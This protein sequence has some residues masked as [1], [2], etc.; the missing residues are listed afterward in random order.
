MNESEAI[1]DLSAIELAVEFT[2]AD[3]HSNE[4]YL[5]RQSGDFLYFSDLG[6]SDEE[7]DDFEDSMR[8][9]AMP[10]QHE[11]GLGRDLAAKFVAEQAPH[12]ADDLR[13]AFS[14]RGGY[15]RFKALMETHGLLD[16]WYEYESKAERQAICRWCDE[17][18][19]RYR[20]DDPSAGE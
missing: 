7:P 4:A 13:K 19:I 11:L 15:R 6:D 10:N 16:A 1:F 9:I 14:H 12:L 20:I 17:H 5:D 8:Y 2:S 3:P 18:G